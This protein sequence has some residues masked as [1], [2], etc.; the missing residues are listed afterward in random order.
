LPGPS[1]SNG[2]GGKAAEVT[3]S[4]YR[5]DLRSLDKSQKKNGQSSAKRC[6]IFKNPK[7][8][9]VPKRNI[10]TSGKSTVSGKGGRLQWFKNVKYFLTQTD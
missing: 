4:P 3:S 6:N 5:S 10:K 7:D 1:T 8:D 9:D 2:G